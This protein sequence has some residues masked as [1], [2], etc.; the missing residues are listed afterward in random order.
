[1]YEPNEPHDEWGRPL[2]E[3]ED[4]KKSNFKKIQDV[5][6]YTFLGLIFLLI[7]GWIILVFLPYYLGRQVW[8]KIETWI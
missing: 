5:F 1:M 2:K 3:V 6:F 8:E 7:F 4:S